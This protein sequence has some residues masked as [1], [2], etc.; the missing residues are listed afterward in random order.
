MHAWLTEQTGIQEWFVAVLRG[1]SYLA[2]RDTTMTS[3]AK[4]L[5]EKQQL[6]ERLQEGPGPHEREQ[7][8]RV[9]AELEET[10]ALLGESG[11]GISGHRHE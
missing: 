7:I 1:N 6:L 5:A 4:L 3:L 2:A 8:Q 10:L 11:P 9:L